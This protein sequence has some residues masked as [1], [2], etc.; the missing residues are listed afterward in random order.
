MMD[1]GYEKKGEELWDLSILVEGK[2][3]HGD[4]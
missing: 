2:Y 1:E 3:L 4:Y